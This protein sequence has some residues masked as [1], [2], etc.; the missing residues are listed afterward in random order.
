ML[1]RVPVIPEEVG[2]GGTRPY[3]TLGP[4]LDGV[5]LDSL[6]MSA[7][8][9]NYRREHFRTASVSL[10]FDR[11]G[12]PCQLMIFNTSLRPRQAEVL[13]LL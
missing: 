12:R 7:G 10:I 5:Y 1:H 2:R 11:E 9:L 3:Q 8:E 4:G 6:E 13:C